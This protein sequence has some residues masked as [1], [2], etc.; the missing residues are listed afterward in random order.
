MKT[1]VLA[2]RRKEI[3]YDAV[4]VP[5]SFGMR[6]VVLVYAEWQANSSVSLCVGRESKGQKVF[7]Q[8]TSPVTEKQIAVVS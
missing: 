5:L 6:S 8:K 1:N 7:S 2:G 4:H 3:H